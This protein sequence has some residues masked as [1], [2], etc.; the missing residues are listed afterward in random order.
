M[1]DPR[2]TKMAE[3]LVN[4]C[5]EVQE[6]DKVALRGALPALPLVVETYRQI[7]H[8]GGHPLLLLED[9]S[10]AQILLR[11]GSDAQIKHVADPVNLM[12]ET[13]DCV[14]NVRG[15][16][17]TRTLSAVDPA[18]QQMASVAGKALLN[19]YMRRASEGSLR[20]VST[21]YPTAA[22]AQD[23][24]MSLAD[25][26][27]FVYS[28]CFADKPDPIAEW[29]SISANQR[30]IID[31]LVGKEQI[32]VNGPNV[33]LSLSVQDRPFINADGKNNMPSG[34]IFTAPVE[35]SVNG[36]VKFTYP[37]IYGGREVSG[38]ELVFEQGKVIQASA[39]KNE[40]FL[41]QMLEADTGAKYLGEFAIGTNEAI[42][43]FTKSI[44]FDEKIAG[45]IH[46]ALGHGYP[47]SGSKNVSAIHWDMIC[48][49]RD[50][51]QIFVDDVLFYDSG[52]FQVG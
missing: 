15:S 46:M 18:K 21:M 30:R 9:E 32:A 8:A 6:G 31:W 13:Y 28:A 2:T 14:I 50:G 19:T 48:D 47:E 52:K 39:E 36:W 51:G 29:R 33:D 43:R 41:L 27:D 25:F 4:Y 12:V 24:D 3:T 7:I 23:A 20:W 1:G 16:D 49:M 11:E 38:I 26:E 45:T 10:F 5:V 34:E 40:A 22:H 42:K 44:L 35:A 17:N 37:A